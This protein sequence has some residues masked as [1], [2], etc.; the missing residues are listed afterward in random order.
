MLILN[1]M[2]NG[3]ACDCRVCRVLIVT[4]IT[5]FARIL[6][7]KNGLYYLVYY[8][9]YIAF[10]ESYYFLCIRKTIEQIYRN[11]CL[12]ISKLFLVAYLSVQNLLFY[13]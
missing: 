3:L 11:K 6:F 12:L 5:D 9:W 7:L 1:D 8:I 2:D 4:Y 10:I 13:N